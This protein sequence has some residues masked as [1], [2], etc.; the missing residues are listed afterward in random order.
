M[1]EIPHSLIVVAARRR[2]DVS[3]DSSSDVT[4]LDSSDV[5]ALLDSD[6]FELIGKG[7]DDVTAQQSQDL[8]TRFYSY[9]QSMCKDMVYQQPLEFVD[10][11]VRLVT[12]SYFACR[13][14]QISPF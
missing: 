10:H 8:Y 2:R 3:S 5:D 9:Q 14:I 12:S 11:P 13:K 7:F 6:A 1:F 4:A